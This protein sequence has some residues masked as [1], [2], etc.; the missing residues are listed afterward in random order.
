M[1][2]YPTVAVMPVRY[3]TTTEVVDRF[4]E[5]GVSVSLETIRRWIKADKLRSKRL[6]GGTRARYL[7]HADDVDALLEVRA[8]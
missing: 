2:A 5:H 1:L 6:P 3:L 7:V 4:A 8:A